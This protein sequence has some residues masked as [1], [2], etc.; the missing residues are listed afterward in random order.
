MESER[1]PPPKGDVMGRLSSKDYKVVSVGR[2]GYGPLA[3][4][5]PYLML[6]PAILL[7][8]LLGASLVL[9]VVYSFFSYVEGGGMSPHLTLEN[10]AR[11]AQTKLY[12]KVILLTVR[13]SLVVTGANFLLSYPLA[14]FLRKSSAR[15]RAA[16]FLMLT[17]P[18]WT[19]VIVRT[20]GWAILLGPFG[21]VNA[22]LE[23]LGAGQSAIN[24][25]PGFWAVV[26]GL[27]EITM[28][29]M[30][31]PIYTSLLAID[32]HVEEISLTLGANPARTFIYVTF[33]LSSPGIFAGVVLSY[34][35]VLS[36]YVTPVILGSPRELVLPVLIESQ[37]SRLYNIPFASALALLMLLLM[38]IVVLLFR[39]FIRLDQLFGR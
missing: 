31:L 6:S 38:S 39:R 32:P 8:L 37:V 1:R 9:L 4:V 22:V 26:L 30:T 16:G 20:Y 36:A 5:R 15:V 21:A 18:L 17:I 12:L 19:S 7:L 33:P 11:I 25:Y 2:A 29:L 13:L 3:T 14:Y 27:L 35:F 34:A 28:P 23:R 10:Y 24:I